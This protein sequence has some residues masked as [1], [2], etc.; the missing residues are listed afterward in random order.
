MLSVYT[1]HEVVLNLT[2]AIVD[3]LL[4]MSG[5]PDHAPRANEDF[6]WF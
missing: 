2:G 3:V 5:G 1:I 6:V 4:R